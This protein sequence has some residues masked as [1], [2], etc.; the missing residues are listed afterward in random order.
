MNT[1]FLEVFQEYVG[2]VGVLVSIFLGLEAFK[3]SNNHQNWNLSLIRLAPARSVLKSIVAL[4]LL[5]KQSKLQSYYL[6]TLLEKLTVKS[7]VFKETI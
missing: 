5:A 7:E 4:G 6:K 3:K 1:L 2:V